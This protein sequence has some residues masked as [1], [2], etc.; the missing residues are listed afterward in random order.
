[1]AQNIALLS[2]TLDTGSNSHK[3]WESQQDHHLSLLIPAPPTRL[4]REEA[5]VTAPFRALLVFSGGRVDL[6]QHDF[7]KEYKPSKNADLCAS[8]LDLAIEKSFGKLTD[9]EMLTILSRPV[10][11]SRMVTDTQDLEAQRT[12]LLHCLYIK[13][14]DG[15]LVR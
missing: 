1:L 2:G 11:L 6:Q 10:V 3:L 8:V 15:F 4:K 14:P 12:K 7:A 13:Y 9:M 5:Q